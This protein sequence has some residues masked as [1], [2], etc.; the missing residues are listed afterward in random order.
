MDNIKKPVSVIFYFNH[1][2]RSAKPYK[3]LLNDTPYLIKKIGL[4][5]KTKVGNDLMHIFTVNTESLF[6]KL[7]FNTSNLSWHVESIKDA[8]LDI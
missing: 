5:Y 6:L 8:I 1:K 2:T 4:H 3:V 7:I